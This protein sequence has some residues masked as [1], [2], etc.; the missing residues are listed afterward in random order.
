MIEYNLSTNNVDTSIS[1][2][3]LFSRSQSSISR[4]DEVDESHITQLSKS[5]VVLTFQIEV[6]FTN[7]LKEFIYWFNSYSIQTI[8][9]P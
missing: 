3:Q 6:R 9:P 2:F 4:G 8:T 7:N 1:M 5:D